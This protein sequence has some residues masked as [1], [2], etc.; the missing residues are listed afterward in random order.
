MQFVGAHA[1]LVILASAYQAWFAL[2]W[3]WTLAHHVTD[4]VA[5]LALTIVLMEESVLKSA[6]T[7]R[8]ASCTTKQALGLTISSL[9]RGWRFR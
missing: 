1:L 6:S 8:A 2:D 3:L 9:K 7:T 5:V 4:P